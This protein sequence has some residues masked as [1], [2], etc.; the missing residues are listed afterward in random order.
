VREASAVR[1]PAASDGRAHAVELRTSGLAPFYDGY[2]TED[3]RSW[4]LEARGPL[5]PPSAPISSWRLCI[6]SRRTCDSPA[7][8]LER[9]NVETDRIAL[10]LN[11][12]FNRVAVRLRGSITDINLAPVA[13]ISGGLITN[14]ER[15][16]TQREL[17][18]TASCAPRRASATGSASRSCANQHIARRG[19]PRLGLADPTR[20]SSLPTWPGVPLRLQPSCSRWARTSSTPQRRAPSGRCLAKWAWKARHS[21]RRSL[22]GTAGI[23]YAQY[24]YAAVAIEERI[25]SRAGL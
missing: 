25:L 22:V 24:P 17:P 21:L 19:E 10:V 8:A 2:E 12:Q 11:H 18:P 1:E 16:T 23:R 14:A 15:N 5:A 3:D 6:R 9:G 13:S 4:A 20:S 7:D